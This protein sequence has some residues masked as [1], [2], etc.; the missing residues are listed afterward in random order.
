VW[1]NDEHAMTLG[2]RQIV[3][4]TSTGTTTTNYPMATMTT[5]PGS[6]INTVLGADIPVGS[7]I[8]SGDQAGTDPAGRPMY[9]ALFITDITSNPSS[10]AGDWQ[11]GGTPI[12]PDAVFGTW[13]GAIKTI[14][15]VTNT[16]TVTPDADVV[17]NNWNLGTGSDPVPGTFSNE[18]YGSEV[19][20]NV[21]DLPLLP[22]HVYRIQF[23]VH[24]GDQNKAGGDVGQACMLVAR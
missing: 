4:T 11:Y 5:N 9:P 24:D 2:V 21:N 7:T 16:V 10:K 3:V 19:R 18:G 1:A 20:W 12:V 14:N 8:M 13:K 23:M 22:G 6:V 15:K 17:K